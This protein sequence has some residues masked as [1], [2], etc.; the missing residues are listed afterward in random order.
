ML[1]LVDSKMA[2]KHWRRAERRKSQHVGKEE[3]IDMQNGGLKKEQDREILRDEVSEMPPIDT[4]I[5][6]RE[7][8]FS[9][10]VEMNL[11]TQ[12][13]EQA[14]WEKGNDALA[15]DKEH[16]EEG[17]VVHAIE[18]GTEGN[19]D[20]YKEPDLQKRSRWGD[21][22]EEQGSDVE[23]MKDVEGF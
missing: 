17:E 11:Q 18:G 7:P 10:Q 2:R 20:S 1:G 14:V 3:T 21:E 8:S 13:K 6:Q 23:K 15:L 19:L 12:M 4:T 5:E 22:A 9:M 16:V